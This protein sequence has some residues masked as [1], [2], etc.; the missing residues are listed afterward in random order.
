MRTVADVLFYLRHRVNEPSTC[1][2][3]VF[4]CRDRKMRG[5]I[6][7]GFLLKLT[8]GDESLFFTIVDPEFYDQVD[9]AL[10]KREI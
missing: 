2:E 8:I 1:R 5:E 6:V 3:N 7:Q 4:V 10:A 9:T